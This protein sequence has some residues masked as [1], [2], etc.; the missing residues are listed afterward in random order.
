ME[1]ISLLFIV[2]VNTTVIIFELTHYLYA[3]FAYKNHILC[4]VNSETST[5]G[6]KN[7]ISI[8]KHFVQ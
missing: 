3:E 8:L 2:S 6:D 4:S 7:T 1:N 5:L